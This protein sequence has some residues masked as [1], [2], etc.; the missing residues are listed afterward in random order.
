MSI[1]N[2]ATLEYLNNPSAQCNL[3]IPLTQAIQRRTL[4]Q[5]PPTQDSVKYS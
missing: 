3:S 1:I 5:S 2:P 4:T